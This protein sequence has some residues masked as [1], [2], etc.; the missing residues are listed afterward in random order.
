METKGEFVTDAPAETQQPPLAWPEAA[1]VFRVLMWVPVFFLPLPVPG[2]GTPPDLV[3][4]VLALGGLMG[5]SNPAVRPLR[6]AAQLGFVLS[7]ARIALVVGGASAAL[8][9]GFYLAASVAAVVL[10]V[11][12]GALAATMARAAD[13]APFAATAESHRW[14]FAIHPAMPAMAAILFRLTQGGLGGLLLAYV[15]LFLDACVIYAVMR[16]M[17]RAAR[18]CRKQQMIGGTQD[19]D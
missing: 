10:V 18:L 2:L 15:P 9:L 5:V 19:A 13:N 6:R 8:H 12:A 11:L 1:R 17:E 7:A 14:V 16:V 4:W 3:G